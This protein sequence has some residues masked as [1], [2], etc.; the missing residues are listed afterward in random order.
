L[1]LAGKRL[2]VFGFGLLSVLDFTTRPFNRIQ[3]SQPAVS[4]ISN[5]QRIEQL[6]F[7]RFHQQMKMVRRQARARGP[8]N[9][10]W[11]S[12]AAGRHH[13]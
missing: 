9:R 10:S 4:P 11:R 1:G 5:R 7:R 13:L 2:S 3:V 6:E 8:A 12:N